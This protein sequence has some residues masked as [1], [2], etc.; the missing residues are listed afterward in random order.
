[1]TTGK[2]IFSVIGTVAVIGAMVAAFMPK[3]ISVDGAKVLEGALRVSID[4]DGK[5]RVK[6]RYVLTAPVAGQLERI[7]VQAGDV[8][9]ANQTM[10]QITPLNAPLLDQR[11]RSE[12][13]ARVNAA[14][15]SLERAKS[16]SEQTRIDFEY[17]QKER[18]RI[19]QLLQR[20]GAT[21]AESERFLHQE[22]QAKKNYDNAQLDL[23]VAEYELQAR[24]ALLRSGDPPSTAAVLPAGASAGSSTKVELL[25]PAAGRVLRVLQPS[26]GVVA[27]GT[28][29]LEIG[30]PT[31][32]EVVV[33]LL[34][35]DAVNVKP[36]APVEIR[37]WGGDKPLTGKVRLIE[38]SGF[39]KV[40]A[41]G[42]EEQRI[43][44]LI[45]L[46]DAPDLHR[47]GDG[48]RIEAQITIWENPKV[49]K[50]PNRAL[51]R[52][53][54]SWAVFVIHEN[55][56]TRRLVQIGQRSGT[57]AQVLSGV[58][59]GDV[60]IVSPGDSVEEQTRVAAR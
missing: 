11:T 22:L 10:A 51:F 33:D 8:V 50:I 9:R 57:E 47:L 31:A 17:A 54:D 24:S 56:A 26:A 3:P 48:Y 7:T 43:N 52:Q 18:V 53:G 60:V 39:T 45:D 15:A 16:A 21:S 37:H 1:M 32:I 12:T 55:K 58:S 35:I 46:D 40:S 4:Q 20:G 29:L 23:K 28:P 30:D 34:T 6:L 42:V 41:L 36:G 2:K 44:A 13:V 38:P 5:T 27:L 14:S 59:A 49:L 25:A 19:E